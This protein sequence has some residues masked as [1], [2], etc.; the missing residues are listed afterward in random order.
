MKVFSFIY[1]EFERNVAVCLCAAYPRVR[2]FDR[3]N[4]VVAGRSLVLDCRAWGWRPPNVSWYRG[5]LQLNLTDPRVKLSTAP[6]SQAKDSRLI[7][8]G[9][10]QSDRANYTCV[11]WSDDWVKDVGRQQYNASVLVRVKGSLQHF[12][13]LFHA[14]LITN[15]KFEQS[16]RDAR[17]PIAFPVQ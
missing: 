2:G 4:S 9:V 5:P 17:K 13:I 8:D 12:S 3:S 15:K 16:S 7:I 10:E 6:G 1:S 11:A 14:Y